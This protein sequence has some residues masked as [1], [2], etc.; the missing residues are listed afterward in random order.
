MLNETDALLENML[1]N[2]VFCEHIYSEDP[3]AYGETR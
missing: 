2:D 1:R 3:R